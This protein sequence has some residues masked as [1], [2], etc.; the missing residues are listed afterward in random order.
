MSGNVF[1]KVLGRQVRA[2][3]LLRGRINR[4]YVEEQLSSTRRARAFLPKPAAHLDSKFGR[5]Q[6]LLYEDDARPG[7]IALRGI[8]L[9]E[10]KAL[11]KG[12]RLAAL[13]LVRAHIRDR[14]PKLSLAD[15]HDRATEYIDKAWPRGR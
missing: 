4:A 7:A 2:G 12:S 1:D 9:D 8:D 10:L 6:E 15:E 5:L 13:K 11:A 14:E 3:S